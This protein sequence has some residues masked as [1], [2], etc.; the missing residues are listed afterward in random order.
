MDIKDL[1]NRAKSGDAAAIRAL[2][3]EYHDKLYFFC[4]MLTSDIEEANGVFQYSF[5]QAFH[6]LSMLKMPENFK[7][8]LYIIAANRARMLPREENDFEE[9]SPHLNLRV[10]YEVSDLT[11]FPE[12]EEEEARKNVLS[13][14]EKLPFSARLAEML[15][16]YCGISLTQIA[17]ILECGEDEVCLYISDAVYALNEGAKQYPV[18]ASF[19]A[20]TQIG[21]YYFRCAEDTQVEET[22]TEEIIATSVTLAISANVVSAQPPAEESEGESEPEQEGESAAAGESAAEEPAANGF[23]TEPEDLSGQE[24]VSGETNVPAKTKEKKE[25]APMSAEAK[26]AL[27]NVIIIVVVIL[28]AAGIM[29]GALTIIRNAAKNPPPVDKET[30]GES[31][32]VGTTESFEPVTTEPDESDPPVTEPEET[33]PPVTQ[34]PETD[35]PETQPEE[36]DPPASET[37]PEP[38]Q[39]E[40]DMNFECTVTDAG[41]VITKYTGTAKEVILP[42]AIDGKPVVAISGMAFES[43][44]SVVSVKIPAGVTSIGQAAF[45]NCSALTSVSLPSSLTS[46]DTYAFYNCTSLSGLK[47]PAGV[48]TIGLSAFYN[49]AWQTSQKTAFVV[50]GDGILISC[51]SGDAD[52]TVPETVKK[53]TNAFYYKNSSVNVTLSAGITEIGTFAFT[54]CPKLKTITIPETVSVMGKDAIYDCKALTAVYVKKG[55]YAES[56]LKDNGFSAKIQYIE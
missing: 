37:E 21:I 29:T 39:A 19:D 9:H 6:K 4:K 31:T 55:S 49:T 56:W 23:D 42:S 25:K 53:M 17:K 40:P 3:L 32:D 20:F 48:K 47:I 43:N 36:T 34:P 24:M 13:L 35:P 30:A 44:T 11:E 5:Y 50:V 16:F 51:L 45:R 33:D 18:L 27:R 41:V 54:G 14:T 46:I 26:A 52:V 7:N 8:W 12:L 15:Y 38:E 22:L 28:M 10:R 2:Y 1:V